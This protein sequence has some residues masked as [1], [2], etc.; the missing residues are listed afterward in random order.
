MMKLLGSTTSPYVRRLRLWLADPSCQQGDYEFVALN[1]FEGEGRD[2]LKASNP[3]LK[4][5][6]LQD[7]R[8]QLYDSRVIF[9]YLSQKF[10]R[11]ALS[12]DQENSLTVID[13]ASDSFVALLLLARS[14]VATDQP[15]LFFTL[16]HERIA[17]TLTLLDE[18]VAAGGFE[19]WDYPAICL[20][21]LL[22]WVMMRKLFDVNACPNLLRFY[23]Q[24]LQQPG[25]QESDPR[26]A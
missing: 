19:Q 21:C 3:A 22:D 14:G 17:S 15:T 12:W 24:N 7:G 20:F 9:R 16:Q 4:V 8:Q 25:I 23:R 13:A 2:T 11:P 18:Q 6:M 5:P 10:G 26:N 1:I